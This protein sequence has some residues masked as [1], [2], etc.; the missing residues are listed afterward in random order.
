MRSYFEIFSS[1]R[2][3]LLPV[4]GDQ[5]TTM[6]IALSLSEHREIPLAVGFCLTLALEED[7]R[8]PME[9]LDEVAQMFDEDDPDDEI[10]IED[11]SRL[12][13]LNQRMA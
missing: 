3:I 13:E 4:V 10:A 1:L 2:D 6:E 5:D 7:V 11:I 9:L 12:R 8:V